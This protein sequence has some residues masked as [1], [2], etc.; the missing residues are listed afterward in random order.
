VIRRRSTA[1][2]IARKTPAANAYHFVNNAFWTNDDGMQI[3][4]WSTSGYL[5]PMIDLSRL[6]VYTQPRSTYLDNQAPAFHFDSTL[7][8]TSSNILPP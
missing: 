1:A 7:P 2:G 4:K 6:R 3:V 8:P 5:T